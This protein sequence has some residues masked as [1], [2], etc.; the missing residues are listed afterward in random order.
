MVSISRKCASKFSRIPHENRSVS[1]DPLA[2]QTLSRGAAHDC[3]RCRAQCRDFQK[4]D[5]TRENRHFLQLARIVRACAPA[6]TSRAR[7]VKTRPR[8]MFLARKKFRKK[9]RRRARD[10]R[11]F[12]AACA[13]P[14]RDTHFARRTIRAPPHHHDARDSALCMHARL[15]RAIRSHPGE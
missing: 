14:A 9:S 2:P 1:R 7:D 4:R 11:F 8:V 6:R 3:A 10:A 15:S 13:A 12:C 5:F